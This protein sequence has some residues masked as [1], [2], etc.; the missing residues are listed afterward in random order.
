MFGTS[1]NRYC[2]TTG[3]QMHF[4]KRY[5]Y[6]AHILHHVLRTYIT[7][8][9]LLAGCA[10]SCISVT[11]KYGLDLIGYSTWRNTERIRWNCSRSFTDWRRKSSRARRR[12]TRVESVMSLTLTRRRTKR[13]GLKSISVYRTIFNFYCKMTYRCDIF[14]NLAGWQY[15]RRRGCFVWS[16]GRP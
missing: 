13:W 6:Y 2:V 4:Y 14:I 15:H 16:I 3:K 12:S 5:M 9:N 11:P 1:C 10:T 7:A 8:E